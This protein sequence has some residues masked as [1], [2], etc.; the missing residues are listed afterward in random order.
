MEF[1]QFVDLILIHILECMKKIQ[2]EAKEILEKVDCFFPK[3][4]DGQESI[5]WLHKYSNNKKQD[6]WAGFFFEDFC[7]LILSKFLGG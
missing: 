4:F 1:I 2:I 5:L 6:E 3:E 7:F